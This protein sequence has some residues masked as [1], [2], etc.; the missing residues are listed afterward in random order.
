MFYELYSDL[1]A[2]YVYW[3]KAENWDFLIWK[4]PHVRVVK[5]WDSWYDLIFESQED[6]NKYKKE[7]L[8]VTLSNINEEIN[9]LERCL[10]RKRKDLLFWENFLAT[11]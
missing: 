6:L 11:K 10:D 3:R 1:S 7:V 4:E 2:S 5:P 9:E 8:P